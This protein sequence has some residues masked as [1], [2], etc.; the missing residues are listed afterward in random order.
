MRLT[1]FSSTPHEGQIAEVMA[2]LAPI[3]R[4]CY[5][6]HSKL[7]AQPFSTVSKHVRVLKKSVSEQIYLR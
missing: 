6:R 4:S 7:R 5:H 2:G 1:R 3:P